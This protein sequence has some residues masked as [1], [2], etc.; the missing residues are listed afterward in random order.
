MRVTTTTLPL[1]PTRTG[2]TITRPIR[3]RTPMDTATTTMPLARGSRQP[4]TA[5]TITRPPRTLM[6]TTPPIPWQAHERTVTTTMAD[7]EAHAPRSRPLM[8]DHAH[9]H[10]DHA[11]CCPRA[12]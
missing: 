4:L 7:I 9:G 12:R 10:D 1:R 8:D 2:M 5:M 11:P 3:L 6:T